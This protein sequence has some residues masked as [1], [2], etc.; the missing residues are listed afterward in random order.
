MPMITEPRGGPKLSLLRKLWTGQSSPKACSHLEMVKT[1][2]AQSQVCEQ[3]VAMGDS[4]PDLRMCMTCGHV[5]CCDEAK[6][7][8]AFKHFK[9]T[10]HPIVGPVAESG[11]LPSWMWCYVDE[12]VI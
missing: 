3:C 4:W 8:H 10:G 9:E 1:L 5:G 12:A 11:K 7:R 6:N 2:Q